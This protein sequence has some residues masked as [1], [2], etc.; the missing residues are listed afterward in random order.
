MGI[1]SSF[2]L[3]L[4]PAL[5]CPAL[6]TEPIGATNVLGAGLLCGPANLR[7]YPHVDDCLYISEHI[8]PHDAAGAEYSRPPQWSAGA[9]NPIYRT[10]IHIKYQS[11]RI[12]ISLRG[13]SPAALALWSQLPGQVDI[14]ARFCWARMTPTLKDFRGGTFV[15]GRLGQ[16]E[17]KVYR[18]PETVF[19]SNA[20]ASTVI[21]DSTF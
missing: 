19:L 9:H 14:L 13:G 6:P 4:L 8:F 1:L 2:V 7:H 17:M 11:C 21:D 15:F 5:L 12:D 18:N 3:L 10:P 20:T 16:L